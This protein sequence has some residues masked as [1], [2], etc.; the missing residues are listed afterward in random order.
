M[1]SNDHSQYLHSNAAEDEAVDSSRNGTLWT[2]VA[3]IITSLIAAVLFVSWSVAQLGWIAGPV[4]MIVFALVS[5]YSTVLLVDCY[6]FP[7]PVSGPMRN[8][9]YMDAVRVNLGER[10]ARLC[11]LAQYVV[12]Y[13]TCIASTLTTAISI[14]AIRRSDCYH[15]HGHGSPCHFSERTYMIL[16]GVLQV[17]LCQIPNF[18][19]LWFLSII[20]ATM[21]FTYATLGVGLSIAKV[22]ENGVIHGTLGGIA[23][24]NSATQAQKVWKILQ[25][26]GGIAL[27]FPYSPLVLEIQDTLKS[28]PP[29]NRT[30]KKAN[31][32]ATVI[33]TA[34][35][36]LCGC[37]G[38]A[39]FGENTP[40]NL[41][42]GFG[43]YEPYWLVDFANA[44]IVAHLLGAYQ[45]FCQ[46][47]FAFAEG[48]I[49]DKWPN[50]KVINKFQLL[51]SVPLCGLCRVNLLKLCWR[52]AFVVS[53]TCIAI[54]FPL[55]N[56]MLGVIGAVKFWPLVVYFPVE[57]Y[58]TQK[59]VQRWT[60]KW[61]L[62]QTL[63][64]LSLLVSLVTAIGSIEGLVKDKKT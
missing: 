14:R 44:C 5:L 19:K 62:M 34:L 28:P 10:K 1:A 50:S 39:A 54:L 43:F 58:I 23:T 11:A 46:P 24:A 36:M 61:N 3:N 6:R 60:L 59:K 63:S 33:A 2:A 32:L 20:A 52:T 37:L 25:A 38:Y 7:D 15:K 27:A 47:I 4:A 22:A 30:M 8:R 55:F 26:L 21:S 9:S 16:Y 35:F 13:G 42:A 57:M 45:V 12:F 29:E 18:N 41:L 51:I 48:W 49:S 64:F 53:T 56:D 17:I 31:L 40:G